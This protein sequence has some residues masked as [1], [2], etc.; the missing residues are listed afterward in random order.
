MQPDNDDDVWRSIVENYG[1][2]ADVDLPP[3]APAPAGDDTGADMGD[4]GDDEPDGATGF[5]DEDTFVP[6]PPPPLPRPERDRLVAWTGLFGSPAI[7][8]FA[9]VVGLHLPALVDYVLIGWFVG[10]FGYLVA[11]MPSGPRDPGDDGARL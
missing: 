6:P 2:R 8:L 7:L 9:L 4:S 11:K 5:T 1:E 3:P 10:G